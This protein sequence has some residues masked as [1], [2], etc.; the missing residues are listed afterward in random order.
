MLTVRARG[1]R[2]LTV[3]RAPRQRLSIFVATFGVQI[4][5]FIIIGDMVGPPIGYWMG[6]TNEAYCNFLANRRFPIL[7]SLIVVVPL[8]MLKNI[9]RWRGA[10]NASTAARPPLARP[11][12]ARSSPVARGAVCGS[13]PSSPCSPSPTSSL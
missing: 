8:A 11:Q 10:R 7:L 3:R 5:Y 1:H 6:D 12:R 9:N 13:R 2:P 4:S